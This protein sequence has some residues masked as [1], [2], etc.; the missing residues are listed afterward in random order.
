MVEAK[1]SKHPSVERVATAYAP[2]KDL[3]SRAKRH[4]TTGHRRLAALLQLRKSYHNRYQGR[5]RNCRFAINTASGNEQERSK[6][7]RIGTAIRWPGGRMP[8]SNQMI[9]SIQIIEH[10]PPRTWPAETGRE[11]TVVETLALR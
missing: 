2:G 5:A 8:T 4:W 6:D 9:T 11:R 7:Q 3:I 1:G 10:P